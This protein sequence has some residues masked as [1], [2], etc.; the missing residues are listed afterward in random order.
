MGIFW[1]HMEGDFENYDGYGYAQRHVSP[2]GSGNWTGYGPVHSVKDDVSFLTQL[3]VGVDW[4]FACHW[5]AQIGY[6]VVAATGMA[7]ADSEIRCTSTTPKK[8]PT[9][10]RRLPATARGLRRDHV[11]LLRKIR[12]ACPRLRGPGSPVAPAPAGVRMPTQAWAW[13]PPRQLACLGRL[14]KPSYWAAISIL[15]IFTRV[16]FAGGRSG[17]GSFSRRRN[18]CTVSFGPWS[19]PP[20]WR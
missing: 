14:E 13:H 17:D 12:V 16:R 3:D 9:E 11:P 15:A 19:A 18:F 5:S 8:S 7:T 20:R 10:E 4:A 2:N 6:R 1:N